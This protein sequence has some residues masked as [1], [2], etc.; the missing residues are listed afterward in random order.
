MI[1]WRRYG[2]A[3]W[4]AASSVGYRKIGDQDI[5]IGNVYVATVTNQDG[6]CTVC[7]FMWVAYVMRFIVST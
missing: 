5:S 7:V 2:A 6:D 1:F 4:R 3:A